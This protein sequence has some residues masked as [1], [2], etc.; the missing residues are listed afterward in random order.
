MAT[1]CRTVAT[2]Q[3]QRP[4]LGHGSFC[5]YCGIPVPLHSLGYLYFG[6]SRLTILHLFLHAVTSFWASYASSLY[7]CLVLLLYLRHIPIC[8]PRSS[9]AHLASPCYPNHTPSGGAGGSDRGVVQCKICDRPMSPR[10]CQSGPA[11]V[12]SHLQGRI[13][14]VQ[15]RVTHL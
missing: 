13:C 15:G 10:P 2:E 3:C 14:C 12:P 11:S 9:G 4:N 7:I 6:P 1:H 8:W 5:S